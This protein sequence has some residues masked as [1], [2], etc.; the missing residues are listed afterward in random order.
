[1]RIGNL[2]VYGIIYKIENLENGKVYIGQTTNK[3]GVRGRYKISKKTSLIEGIFKYHSH[4]KKNNKR[5]FNAHLFYS[6]QKYGFKNFKIQTIL[7]FAFT[8]KE[9]DIKEKVYISSSK[10]FEPK[11][12][13]NNQLGGSGGKN[14]LRTIEKSIKTQIKNGQTR[15]VKQLEVPS[16]KLIKTYP[17]L[18]IATKTLGLS[19]SSIKNVLNPKYRSSLT[20]GGYAWEYVD[21][22][23]AKYIG[24]DP[25]RIFK[26]EDEN[27]IKRILDLYEQQNSIK[28]ISN[29]LEVSEAKVSKI[30]KDSNVKSIKSIKSLEAQLKRKE[31]LS[32]FTKGKSKKEIIEFTG[33]SRSVVEKTVE[34]YNKGLIDINGIYFLKE[35]GEIL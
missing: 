13:Y 10:S 16:L 12:G 8:K 31:V 21:C 15:Y 27:I 35:K 30:L 33:Y 14:N 22:P 5:G 26:K 7:D 32:Y 19:R 9:L 18:S 29:I 20:A 2:E 24:K 1:M 23:N 6:I 3:D 34:K 11:Y 25:Y 4:L 17:S 28:K